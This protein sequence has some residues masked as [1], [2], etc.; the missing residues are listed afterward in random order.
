MVV[1]HIFSPSTQEAEAGGSLKPGFLEKQ[2]VF[3]N[4]EPFFQP[5]NKYI[6]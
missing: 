1:V 6:F 3:L 2:P 4:N 5:Q